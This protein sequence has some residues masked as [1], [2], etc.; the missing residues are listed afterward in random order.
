MGGHPI[1]FRP[2]MGLLCAGGGFIS[3]LLA[4]GS[5]R[6]KEKFE[7]DETFEMDEEDEDHEVPRTLPS[8]S[9]SLPCASPDA[10]EGPRNRCEQIFFSIYVLMEA[11]W[12]LVFTPVWLLVL[13]PVW[14][15]CWPFMHLDC[16]R[17]IDRWRRRNEDLTEDFVDLLS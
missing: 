15:F 4:F 3:S 7:M 16:W 17:S 13:S 9:K 1:V 12:L 8:L 14:L 5:L 11:V 2:S 6:A 10:L